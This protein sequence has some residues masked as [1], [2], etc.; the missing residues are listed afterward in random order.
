MEID[1]HRIEIGV[2]IG[3]TVFPDDPSPAGTL[4]ANADLALYQAKKAGRGTWRRYHPNMPTRRKRRQVDDRAIREALKQ[5]QF[6]LRFQPI[7]RISDLAVIGIEAE[8]NWDHPRRDQRA[9]TSFLQ[10]IAGSKEMPA[11]TEWILAHAVPPLASWQALAP[12]AALAVNLPAQA[13]ASD[14]LVALVR[15]PLAASGIDPSHLVLELSENLLAEDMASN[16]TVRA[17]HG[18]GVRLALDDFGVGYWS[19][20]RLKTMPLD[21]I[22][23]D[24]SFIANLNGHGQDTAVVES[25]IGI[26]DSLHLNSVALGV[27]TAEQL[28]TL[29]GLGASAAQ[30]TLFAPPIAASDVAAWL[31]MWRERCNHHRGLDL[32]RRG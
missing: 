5:G 4:V 15:A 29:G 13:L 28:A 11:V 27:D 32:L 18:L 2:S 31:T 23:I 9:M 19:L 3:I 6:E 24:A 10:D 7:V 22:K 16:D 8:L 1:G 12:E 25:I 21:Q 17:L 14:D 26:A 20:S 30:G